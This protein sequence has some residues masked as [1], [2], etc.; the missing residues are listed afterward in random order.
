MTLKVSYDV[1]NMT[2]KSSMTIKAN[3]EDLLN[4]KKRRKNNS[5]LREISLRSVSSRHPLNVKPEGNLLL[6]EYNS[7]IEG[8]RKKQ[9]G[10]F[11][12]FE[13]DLL[14]DIMSYIKN[15]EDLKNLSHT[16]RFMYAYLYD[17]DLWKMKYISQYFSSG[18][19]PVKSRPWKGSWRST[20]L[21]IAEQEQ[22]KLQVAE[23]ILC[24]DVLYRPFQCSQIE[25]PNL[26]AD[27]I[28]EEDINRKQ[29]NRDL[30]SSNPL[31]LQKIPR[32]SEEALSMQ[33]FIERWHGE[34]FILNSSSD[35][36][37]PNWNIE[38]LLKRFPEVP[39]RQEAVEWNLSSYV[40]YLKSNQDESPLY[41][42]DCN[43]IAMKNLK[44]EYIPP[45]IFQYDLFSVF[46][47]ESINCRPDH[48]WLIVGPERSGST[49]HK[50]PNNTSA[51]NTTL[52][53][54]KLWV[55]LPPG[56]TPPGVSTDKDEGE[57]TSPVGIAEWVLS[58]FFND[59][60][61]IQECKIGVTFPGECLYVPSNWWHLVINLDNSVAVT[62]NFVPLP[63]LTKTLEFFKSKGEQVSGFRPKEVKDALE[64]IIKQALVEDNEIIK[65]KEYCHMFNALKLDPYLQSEDCG[66]LTQLP[67]IPIYELFKKLLV[68]NG[69]LKELSASLEN[70]LNDNTQSRATTG[71]NKL[72]K[73]LTTDRDNKKNS[74]SFDF[75]V[76]EEPD[77]QVS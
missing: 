63:T 54:R 16:S 69:Y 70:I 20:M 27:I 77:A 48:A 10:V 13:D 39:F 51:W 11:F 34:P 18:R 42:F 59:C 9:M 60:L 2:N 45:K 50:D 43:S 35:E 26:F 12:R 64:H 25:Y 15:V 22:A 21:G 32:L 3:V 66:E 8:E 68:Q 17:E 7:V 71:H 5:L 19:G 74:F 36:R 37:W 75:N 14:M 4:L 6:N 72:W 49:F 53:G 47:Q 41:L 67:Q 55:M 73:K 29:Q 52:S 23:N 65:F 46:E 1:E 38:Y 58:G 76:N 31:H 33:L 30:V 28:H 61:R 56:I 24:S 40:E 57:V 62:Q 44:T